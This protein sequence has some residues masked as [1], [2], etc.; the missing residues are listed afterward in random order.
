MPSDPIE[1][2]IRFDGSPEQFLA[3]LLAVQCGVSAAESGAI[4]RAGA[5]RSEVL[6]VHPLPEPGT[7]A[8]EWLKMALEA[9]P[10]VIGEGKTSIQPVHDS[11]DMYGQPARKHLII[12]PLKGETGHGGAGAYVI[13]AT[14]SQ[15]IDL[16][17]EKLELTVALLSLYEMRVT[18]QRRQVDFRRLRSAMEILASVNEHDRFAAAAMALCNEAASRHQCDRV[19]L[20]FLKGRYVGVKAMSHT[21]KFS[22]K[23][24]LVQDIESSM[25]E[26]HDQDIE[27]V[28]PPPPG[29][30]FVSRAAGELSTRHGPTAVVSLP[31]RR[32][33]D[34]VGV[35]TLERPIDRPFGVQE[36]ETLRLTCELCTARVDGLR[37]TDRWIGARMAGGI[38]K[39]FGAILGPKHTWLKLIALAVFG[40]AIFLT[41]AKGEYRAEASFVVEAIEQRVLPAPFDG[42]I[43]EVYVPLGAKVKKDQLLA[44]LQTSD[45]EL[46]LN[47]SRAEI[48]RYRTEAEAARR[49]GKTAE[50]Q[51]AEAQADQA[52]AKAKRL[53]ERIKQS[54]IRSPIDGTVV[55][56]DLEKQL[57]A[58]VET[59][60][61]LFEIAPIHAM[62]A[63]LAMPEDLIADVRLDMRGQL[64]A[65][66]HPDERIGFQVERIN[67]VAEVVSEKN[68]FKIRARLDETRD[69]MRPGMEGLAKVD[70]GQRHYAWI[71][72]RRLV[73]WVRMK[74]W[75]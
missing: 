2:L 8:P 54:E 45:L 70:I 12:V 30:T 27:V 43:E 28:H 39:G 68:V 31:L 13:Q 48:R 32:E 41:F 5:E 35:L 57:G 9:G 56:G 63:E 10:G 36:I 61:V 40:A 55:V 6:A 15:Q 66:G 17:R 19:S 23:M 62:R 75:W 53:Q 21:E 24:K 51:I 60:N 38:R 16:A 49:D 47:E 50:V 20:G 58:P 71:W 33:G 4:L 11:A 1:E 52:L 59:G 65:T 37:Q 73:N 14:H 74:L 64:A 25:E 18:L 7:A 34:G 22:R 46:Q 42:Y 44:R 3:R 29:V 72:T 67:P 69:W 26:C